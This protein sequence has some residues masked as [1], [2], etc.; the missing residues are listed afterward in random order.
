MWGHGG[1]R[2]FKRMTCKLILLPVAA[3]LVVLA[4]APTSALAATG[5]FHN[6]AEITIPEQGTASAYPST[7]FVQGMAGPVRGVEVALNGVSHTRPR[8]L[9]VL[10]TAPDSRGVILMSDV[11]GDGDVTG[12]SWVFSSTGEPPEMGESCPAQYYRNTNIGLLDVWPGV[13]DS[14]LG[15]LDRYHHKVQNGGWNLYVVDDEAGDS[16]TIAG[17]WSLK[18]ET[19][20]VDTVIPTFGEANPYPAVR[21]A[22]DP[23]NAGSVITDVDVS[24]GGVAHDRLEDLDLLLVGPQGQSTMLISDAC[25]PMYLFEDELVF[26][27]E[28]PLPLPAEP[29][30][31]CGK[32]VQPTNHGLDDTLPPPAPAGPYGASL[33]EFDFTEPNGEWALY[34]FDDDGI[35]GDGYFASRFNLTFQ[36]RPKATLEFAESD[37][38]V[39]EGTEHALTI[40]RSAEGG[41]G[42]ASVTVTPVPGAATSGNDLTPISR[43][44]FAR[45][46]RERTILL[47]PR[48]DGVAEPAETYALTLSDPS[49]DAALG[50]T[51]RVGVTIPASS[52]RAGAGD[53]AGKRLCAGKEATIV[54]SGRRDVLRGTR[55]RDVIVAGAGN[56]IVRAR[57]GNDV[58]CGGRAGIAC[59]AAA[60]E[61]D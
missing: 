56:D 34:A 2:S 37:V 36:T 16:G 60:A 51:A 41:L 21:D 47:H 42:E 45:D 27:D 10:L 18:L 9:D 6:P 33:S 24:I 61:T 59:W 20:P 30:I 17:G 52:G 49:G 13:P 3:V 14:F 53:P 40:R 57:A 46:E 28:T 48:A 55:G 32:K 44:D 12:R 26:D 29:A 7:I 19:D 58:V 5:T 38:Q 22:S 4:L 50:A 35:A 39:A 23:A 15:P 8:D 43:V 25:G 54:G 11:C 1:A 31:I